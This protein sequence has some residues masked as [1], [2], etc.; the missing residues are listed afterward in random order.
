MW[1]ETQY[2]TESSGYVNWRVPAQPWGMQ[3]QKV[4]PASTVWPWSHL[5]ATPGALISCSESMRYAG[6]DRVINYILLMMEYT[7]Q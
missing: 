4:T 2:Q 7:E 5:F 6:G 3:I 1:K